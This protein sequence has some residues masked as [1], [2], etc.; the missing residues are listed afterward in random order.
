MFKRLAATALFIALL[1]GGCAPGIDLTLGGA[2]NS[3]PAVPAWREVVPDMAR[4]ECDRNTCG[5]RLIVYKFAKNKFSWRIENRASPSTVQGWLKSLPDAAFV[6][7]GVFFEEHWMPTGLLKTAGE[8]LGG[9]KYEFAKSGLV[10][11]A[12]ETK[13]IDTAAGDPGLAAMTEAAQSFPLLIKKGSRVAE[14]RDANASRRTA[15]GAD[16]DGNIYLASVPEDA[17]TFSEFAKLL[18]DTAVKWDNVLNLDGGTST[19]FAARAGDWSEAMNSIVQV[20]NVIVAK[21]R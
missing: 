18:A 14:F 2:K 6:S 9:Q 11:L 4:Y 21:H 12:P 10:E 19:G 3:K 5:A 1:G 16:V 13:I 7:N 17:V 8:T 20:P 15:I